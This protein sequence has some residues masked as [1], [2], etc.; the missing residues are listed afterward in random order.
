MKPTAT[1]TSQPARLIPAALLL[2]VPLASLLAQRAEG[3]PTTPQ[4]WQ[5]A[6]QHIIEHAAPTDLIATEPPWREDALVPLAPLQ[7]QFIRNDYEIWREDLHGATGLWIASEAGRVDRALG[8]LPW[9]ATPDKTLPAGSVTALH[10]TVPDALRYQARLS[11]LLNK[12]SVHVVEGQDARACAWQA[13]QARWSCVA[14][15]ANVQVYPRTLEMQDAP[16]RCIWAPPPGGAKRLRVAFPALTLHDTLRLRFGQDLDGARQAGPDMRWRALIEG[17]EIAQGVTKEHVDGW[18]AADVQ[19]AR[20][21]GKPVTLTIEIEA[22]RWER[23][24]M[25]FEG[26]ID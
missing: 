7:A 26:W 2:L 15:G 12:A 4:D 17:E 20:W 9:E 11:D 21:R 5:A 1:L 3:D 23:R 16:R 10:V 19:T 6:A 8:R 22:E 25:C 13:G 18:P 24:H 14:A